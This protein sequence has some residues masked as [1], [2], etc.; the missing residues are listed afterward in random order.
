MKKEFTFIN[1]GKLVDNELVLVLTKTVSADEKKGYSPM[2]QFVMQNKNCGETIGQINLRIGNSENIFYGG[3]IGYDVDEKFRGH[4]Y[5]SRSCK[6]LLP[7]AKK[8]GLQSVTITCDPENVA[9]RRTAELA[10]GILEE[11]VDLP[12]YNEQYQKGE[13]QKCRYKLVNQI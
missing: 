9:S 13:R 1:P 10:G 4:H 2:Y 11:I 3:H 8:H 12:E 5:A 7:L 6:L